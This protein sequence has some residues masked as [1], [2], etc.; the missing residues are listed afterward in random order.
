MNGSEKDFQEK[1]QLNYN[2]N[3]LIVRFSAFNYR[4]V[5]ATRYSYM[6]EGYDKDW[7]EPSGYSFAQY[8]R[9]PPG[10][11]VLHV[12][13]YGSGQPDKEQTLDIVIRHPWWATWWAYLVYF[14]VVIA[15]G[16][17]VYRQLRTIYDL[18]RRI[19]IEK[20]LTEYKLMFFTNISHEFRTPLTIIRGA[21]ERIRSIKEIPAD[22]RQP[23]SNMGRSTDRMLRLINQL[24]EF[25]K[26]QAGKLSLSLEDIDIIGFVRNIYQNFS[27]LAENKQISYSFT[28]NVKAY[29]IPIDRQHIDKVDRKSV[30]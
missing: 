7:S 27:D 8:L 28:S 26:M 24:L 1:L 30:V 10:R 9:L 25:R 5:A 11:Y 23:V 16:Y 29:E 2:E 22:L 19:S 6:L 15:V 21:V 18:R 13:V 14:I 17:V 12:K 20:E 4:D 3:S